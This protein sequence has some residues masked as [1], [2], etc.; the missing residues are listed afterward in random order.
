[1]NTRLQKVLTSSVVFATTLAMSGIATV[2]PVSAAASA[3]DLIKQSGRPEIYYLGSDGKRYVFPNSTTYFTWYKDFSGVVTIP[4][5]ELESYPLGGN[6]TVRPGT[7][8]VKITTNPTVYAVEPGGNL[9]SIVSEE[10]AKALFGDNWAK[11]VIDVPDSFFTNYRQAAPLTAGVYPKGSLVKAS[12]GSDVYYFDGTSFRKFGSE[13]AFTANRFSFDNVMTAPSTITIASNLG[14]TINAAETAIVD[15]SSSGSAIGVQ[16]G[17]GTGI[18]VALAGNTAA[19][20]SIIYGQSSANLGTFTF[21]ASS[22]GDVKVTTLKLKRIG[23]SADALLTNVYLYDGNTKLTDNTSVSAGYIT[24]SN[25]AGLFT[26]AKGTTKTITVKSDISSTASDGSTVGVALNAASDVITNGAAVS[27]SFPANGN[28]MTAASATLATA[29]SASAT[30]A[31]TSVNA[32]SSNATLWST[33]LSVAQRA[34]DLQAIRFKQSGSIAS[35][36]IQNIKLF[37]NGAQA[38]TVTAIDS[39][40]VVAF[41]LASA[42]VR[43]N[44]GNATIELRG[45]V[46]KGSGR[47][48]Q[49]NVQTA[50]DISLVDSNYGVNIT[51]TGAWINGV[52]SATT[53]S[54]GS[55]SVSA[56]SSFV[57]T[58]V[59]KN[60]SGVTL[61]QYTLKAYGEDMKVNN[62][63]VQPTFTGAGVATEGINNISIYVNGAQVGSTQSFV[64]NATPVFPTASGITGTNTTGAVSFGTNNLF[65][66]PAGTTVTLTVKGDLTQ[67]TGTT[68]TAVKA[69]LILQ[70]NQ[71]QGTASLNSYPSSTITTSAGQTLSIVTA[72]GALAKYPGFTNQTVVKNTTR[73]R[74]GSFVLQAGSAES[75]DV[76]N[77]AVTLGG[78]ITDLT[79]INNLYV[80]DNTTP[81]APQSGTNNFPVSYNIP[82]SGSKVVDVYADLGE[83]AN[84]STTIATLAVSAKGHSTQSV[85]SGLSVA[86][87]T[88]TVQTGSLATPTLV[89]DNDSTSKLV[90]GDGTTAQTMGSYKFVATNGSATISEMTFAVTKTATTTANDVVNTITVG[91]QS[92]TPVNSSATITGLNLTVPS[93]SAGL[94]VPVKAIIAKV[95][96]S[97]GASTNN[98]VRLNLLSYK[99]TIGNQVTTATVSGGVPTN[100]MVAVAAIP[101]F[102]LA[103]DN[104]TGNMSPAGVNTVMK[105]TVT[106]GSSNPITLQGVNFTPVWSGTLSAG[107]QLIKV[108]DNSNNALGNT[109]FGA[110]TYAGTQRP[111]TFTNDVT[112]NAGSTQTFRVEADG[113]G[114]GTTGNSLRVD[115]TSD[116]TFGSGTDI[117][118]NDG[119]TST[120]TYLNGYL[121]KNL[122]LT[123][124]TFKN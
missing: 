67:V 96:S 9:R 79:K 20:A 82:A 57:T 109:T 102:S 99:Y 40:G 56:D 115:L 86:G 42:P 3:G 100:A 32:N 2:A 110:T 60:A 80:S 16:A 105:F 65:T 19:A 97:N 81:V 34:V 58:Q 44:T 29:S 68:Q 90:V 121:L 1:M 30:G 120:G 119:A 78:T 46:V 108:Y 48:F 4:R 103:S 5:A 8:L 10:N 83:I 113:T 37:V 69:D 71:A 75:I 114:L 101:V 66:I 98:D 123:G 51:A 63:V 117:Q 118:W 95:D 72:A 47:T 43:L 111:V 45:D 33:T 76:T 17:A 39:N 104:P 124:S 64:E 27:G 49:F 91:T 52:S 59:V 23:V 31:G 112:I 28:L 7:K 53:I 85:L 11:K 24:W 122:N 93:G 88:I 18:S 41:D 6:V 92:A 15:T 87:Q 36:A 14:A 74:I 54:N 77:L 35:D 50:S 70:A 61:A 84:G 21:S 22:D 73:Q 94:V 106:N 55:I 62:L 12:A 25:S 107:T 89:N 26:V 38:G 116:D 13:S